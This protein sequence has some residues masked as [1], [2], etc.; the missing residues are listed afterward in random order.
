VK[1][2]TTTTR[3]FLTLLFTSLPLACGSEQ[4]D[5]DQDPEP[6]LPSTCEV[7]LSEVAVY[8]SVKISLGTGDTAVAT[9][10]AAV[11]AGKPALFR[12][13]LTPTAAAPVEGVTVRLTIQSGAGQRTYDRTGTVAATSRDDDPASTL[14]LAVAKEDLQPDARA[15]VE[16]VAPSHCAGSP[17]TRLPRQGELALRPRSIGP[18]RVRL[19]PLRYDADGSGRLPDTSPAQLQSFQDAL[20]AMFPVSTV[21]FSVREPVPMSVA[22]GPKTGWSTVLDVVRQTRAKDRPADDIYYFGLVAPA[23]THARYCGSGCTTG[24]SFTPREVN[25]GNQASVGLGF[26][27]AIAVEA[28]VHELGHAHGRA[29]APCGRPDRPDPDFPYPEALIGVWGYDARGSGQLRSPELTRDIMG[30]CGPRWVSDYTYRG[31]TERSAQVNHLDAPLVAS[32]LIDSTAGSDPRWRTLILGADGA[33]TWGQATSEIPPSGTAVRAQ[34]LDAAGNPAGAVD[35]L[36][37]EIADSD[38]RMFSV[39]EDTAGAAALVL[40][41]TSPIAFP[42]PTSA[43]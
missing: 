1:H 34:T 15:S 42:A 31:L 43:P 6:Y 14:D 40:P 24:V 19:V 23:D 22:L 17:R 7:E 21:E 8:Q 3:I 18:L 35:I 13:F 28:L 37:I 4:Q 10:S 25:S 29:H 41:G 20:L 32:R 33:I 9:P 38:D 12:V 16:I 5:Q 26:T 36:E 11:I 2:L 39:P 30:Y 27:G